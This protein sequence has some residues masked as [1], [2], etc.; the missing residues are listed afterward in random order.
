MLSATVWV[1]DDFTAGTPGWGVDHFATIQAGVAAV[2]AGGTVN[3]AAG[4]Y[5]GGVNITKSLNL[6]GAQANV[7]PVV[8]GRPGGES[9]LS[10][11]GSFGYNEID[12]NADDVVV[13]GFEVADQYYGIITNEGGAGGTGGLHENVQIVYNYVHSASSGAVAGVV[14]LRNPPATPPQILTNYTIAHNLI[15]GNGKAISMS[16]T[17]GTTFNNL[18]VSFN[19]VSV[20]NYGLFCGANPALYL[21]NDM[22]IE[23]NHFASSDPS[24]APGGGRVN[25]GNIQNGEFT[26]NLVES[27]GG[28][29]GIDTGVISGNTFCN[30]GDMAL[31]GTEYGFTRPSANVEVCNNEFTDEGDGRGLRLR[32]GADASTVSVH[33]NAFRDSGVNPS[34]TIINEGNGTLSVE[35]NWW[36]TTDPAEIA[37]RITGDGSYTPWLTEGTDLDPDTPGFQPTALDTEPPAAPGV[38]LVSDTGVSDTDAVTSN[39]A[40]TLS[41]VEEDALVEYSIDGGATWTGS[42]AATEGLNTVQVR[43]TDLAGNV[44]PATT[45]G[46]TLDTVAPTLTASINAP[47]ADGWYNRV[48][49][50]AVVTY[51][52]ADATSG[53]T[54]P[55]PYRFSDGVD[56]SVA[57][58]TVTDVAGNTSLP[59]GQFSGIH[60]DTGRLKPGLEK[61]NGTLYVVGSRSADSI[62][63]IQAGRS[64]ILVMIVGGGYC[65]QQRVST[66]GVGRL[67]VYGLAGNDLINIQAN[68]TL[69]AVVFGNDGV[70]R[71]LAG[72]GPTVLVGGNGNDTLQAAYGSAVLIGGSGVD[73]LQAGRRG[74][75][76]VG[77]KT[78][79]DSNVAALSAIVD[80]WVRSRTA[81][82]LTPST[83]HDDQAVDYLIGGLGVDYYFANS[84]G[85]VRDWI[86]GNRW[87]DRYQN[88]V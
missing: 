85:R 38:A 30:D 58:I 22:V 9:R 80:E 17:T 43:Q 20:N 88:I 40:I 15:T 37:G 18:T 67:V 13:N 24:T 61:R 36:G 26:N 65:R 66:S 59:A 53:V 64:E 63:V 16:G 27:S 46:F 1:D 72:G 7:T 71:L 81:S 57:A 21:I 50:P 31:W 87:G 86:F 49:G 84:T 68:V 10:G 47:S 42:F 6:L 56:M 51:S 60:Q 4:N 35:G 8:G 62:N 32:I 33:S 52:A 39:G 83:V 41:G 25:I 34:S 48:T 78:D 14:L 5:T 11:D 70:D 74:S 77:G 76:F 75:I 55:A 44:S 19:E 45:F 3:V 54:T 23:G 29:I 28:V 73:Y 2:D 12:I 79:F 82:T 69:P